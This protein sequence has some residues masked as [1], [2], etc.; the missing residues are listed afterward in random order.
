MQPAQY[1]HFLPIDFPKF[2]NN[3]NKEGSSA[4]IVP[5]SDTVAEERQDKIQVCVIG[6]QRN[7]TLVAEVLSQSDVKQ[8][9]AYVNY[10][11]SFRPKPSAVRFATQAY[12]SFGVSTTFVH[13]KDFLPYQRFVSQCNVLLPMIDP[14]ARPQYFPVYLKKLTG[15]IPQVVAYQIATVL[16]SELE[17]IY[18]ES[19]TAPTETYTNATD[20]RD[21]ANA[22]NRMLLRIRDTSRHA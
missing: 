11:I 16:H 21:I 3:K 6:S 13:E 8:H 2:N 7:H 1:C 5:A 14:V 19:F 22:L 9:E 15:A 12:K 20:A 18:H 4:A 10:S 17:Q